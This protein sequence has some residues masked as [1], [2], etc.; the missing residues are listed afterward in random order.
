M[1][2]EKE[3]PSKNNREPHAITPMLATPVDAAFDDKEWV[4]ELKWDGY[5]A[6]AELKKGEVHFYSRRG[7]S[8]KEKYPAITHAL[9]KIKTD[10]V[11]DGEVVLFNEQNR[12]DFQKLQQYS[13]NQHLP[14]IYYVFDILSWQKEDT[15]YLP[16]IERKKILKR[17]I[18]TK[19]TIRYSD[20]IEEN[21]IA[22]FEKVKEDNLEGI[23]AKK[24]D[25]I[26]RPGIRTKEWL[27]I[28]HHHS[29]EAII[30]GFTEPRRSRLHFGALLLAQYDDN[31][32]LRYIGH[33][34]T[35]FSDQTLREMIKKLQPL[36]IA[37]SPLEQKVK[38]NNPVTWVNPQLVCE[39]EFTEI[40]RDGILRHP[41]F[42]ALR[43]DKKPKDI[44]IKTEK[45]LPV[46]EVVKDKTVKTKKAR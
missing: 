6:I 4:F 45:E 23:I 25:S 41:V 22:F 26:Y 30:V 35:G 1:L 18:R 5:R 39:I 17:L 46:K 44:K 16:L 11:I 20:H 28:K 29:Q 12:P 15:K 40:T 9:K 42:K 33:T 7:L 2:P 19:G 24:K 34:G 3:M 27:K 21:G 31:K 14:L 37:K 38:G 43:T 13:E 32:K 36:T 10:M 8:F